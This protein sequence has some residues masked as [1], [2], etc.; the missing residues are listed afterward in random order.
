M[1]RSHRGESVVR[2]VR[3]AVR[4]ELGRVGYLA[5]RIEDV[6][7]RADVAKT[8]IYRR[9]PTKEDL[10]Y[11]FL[12]S[13]MDAPHMLPDSGSLRED[14]LAIARHVRG[15]MSSSDGQAIARM[16]LTAPAEPE[17]RRIV[18]R[19]REHNTGFVVELLDRARSRGELRDGISSDLLLMTLVGA[20]HHRIFVRCTEP[21]ELDLVALVDLLLNGALPRP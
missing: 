8:T 11:D 17:I 20:I 3:D 16:M 10:I 19:V 9:W 7:A 14:L 21:E 13:V 1:N 4:T 2:D 18:D 12:R 6:A 15:V 5:L